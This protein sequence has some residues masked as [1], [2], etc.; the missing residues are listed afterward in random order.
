[1]NKVHYSTFAAED[2][3]ENAAYIARDKPEAANRWIERM[4]EVCQLLVANPELGQLRTTS[5]HVLVEVLC[6]VIMSSFPQCGGWHRSRPHRPRRARSGQFVI[7][8]FFSQETQN[9]RRVTDVGFTR[10]ETRFA[11]LLRKKSLPNAS[12]VP[13]SKTLCRRACRALPCRVARRYF[14]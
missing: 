11:R 13:S 8:E 7:H 3:Y 1:M 14:R 2:L 9:P 10:K 6:P 4:E 12:S 5:S